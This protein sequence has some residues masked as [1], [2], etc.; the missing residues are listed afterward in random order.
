MKIRFSIIYSALFLSLVLTSAFPL[1]ITAQTRPTP[2]LKI[3]IPKLV[4][5]VNGVE[6]ESKYIE[7]RLNQISRKV[8]RPLTV[9]EKT[10]IVKDLIEKEVVRELVNQQGKKEN[11]EIDNELIEKE[12]AALRAT[13]SSEEEFN[14]ALTARNINLEDIKKS[15]QIDINA[16]QLLN[17]QIKGKITIADNEVKKYYDDNK[18]KFVRPEAYHT[19]H[20]LAAY[21]PPEALRNQTIKELQKNKE[22]FAR[23]AEEKIDKVV[24]E[25]K[26][27]ADFEELAKTHS[28]DES[29]RDNGGDLDFIYKGVFEASFDEAAGKLKPGE[30]SGKIQTRF[31]FHVIQLIDKKPSETA[32][33]DE[34]KPGIQKHLFME[35]AKKQVAAYVE[36]LRQTAKIETFF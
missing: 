24:D 26:K 33:F 7:F 20:I 2:K 6:I 11:L 19:R 9:Q 5:R 28:D 36:K 34:M 15:M 31:G 1:A 25:L 10:S 8:N 18:P 22:Y 27:G 3:E 14:T 17:E 29:S 32:T 23:L 21:F 12:L 30:T 4:A 16:R 13:Y 35:E